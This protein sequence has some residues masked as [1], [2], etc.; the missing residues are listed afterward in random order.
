VRKLG[1]FKRAEDREKE[2]EKR[3]GKE[4]RSPL[5]SPFGYRTPKRIIIFSTMKHQKQQN[6]EWWTSKCGVGK[7]GQDFSLNKK[8]EE[9]FFY[10]KEI[11]FG[12]LKPLVGFVRAGS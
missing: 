11:L 5:F 9:N 1:V 6:K 2:K 8:E 4:K 10:A 12:P 7:N 3:K